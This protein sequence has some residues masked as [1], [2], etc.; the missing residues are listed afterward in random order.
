[1]LSLK[2]Q[3][4]TSEE[5]R[6]LLRLPLSLSEEVLYIWLISGRLRVSYKSAKQE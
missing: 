3:H 1:M 5:E 2:T 6:S 4:V